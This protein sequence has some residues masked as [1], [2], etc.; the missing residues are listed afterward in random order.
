MTTRHRLALVG[1]YRRCPVATGEES[2]PV[3]QS[4][5]IDRGVSVVGAMCTLDKRGC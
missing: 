2:W 5:D 1:F 3:V 4:L